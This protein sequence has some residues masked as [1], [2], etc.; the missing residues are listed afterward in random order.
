MLDR[1]VPEAGTRTLVELL[2]MREWAVGE[3]RRLRM[4]AGLLSDN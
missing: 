3:I 4:D 2:Q 1:L